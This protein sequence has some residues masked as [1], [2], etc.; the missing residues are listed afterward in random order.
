MQWDLPVPTDGHEHAPCLVLVD[1]SA[2]ARAAPR[3][4]L[5]HEVVRST[6]RRGSRGI[7]DPE[8]T[9]LRRA[10]REPDDEDGVE[11]LAT[12]DPGVDLIGLL[13]GGVLDGIDR[14]RRA[15]AEKQARAALAATPAS[16][17]EVVWE[18]Y[19]YEV[20]T[21]EAARSGVLRAALVDR[22]LGLAW[23][24]ERVVRETRRFSVAAGRNAK[25]R[26]LLESPGGDQAVAA[27][28]TVWEHGGLQPSLSGLMGLLA[29]AP[30]DGVALDAR[31]LATA[32]A[33]APVHLAASPSGAADADPDPPTAES[34]D[35]PVMSPPRA[36]SV[37]QVVTADGVRRYRL[38]APAAP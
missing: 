23:P 13:A 22:R 24:I 1:R 34:G 17:E 27:D 12:G 38:V 11:V 6:Y 16:L 4:L 3:R 32:W 29:A 10:L 28:V 33:T 2:T 37:E 31:G 14:F 15:S 8:H 19:T 26:Q 9:E 36:S 20:T 21:I 18:P 35:G 7:A 30:G 25:D 5:A